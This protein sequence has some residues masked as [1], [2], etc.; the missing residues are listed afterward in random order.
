MRS[1]SS[2]ARP[3][4]PLLNT[5]FASCNTGGM[6]SASVLRMWRRNMR[7][8]KPSLYYPCPALQITLFHA[9][10]HLALCG[11]QKPKSRYARPFD[12]LDGGARAPGCN[13]EVEVRRLQ[14]M[15]IYFDATDTQS[16]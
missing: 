5:K 1:K 7:R 6:L 16:F 8:I 15:Q 14:Q 10:L 12:P 11:G 13:R 2:A 9:G 4:S 3:Y